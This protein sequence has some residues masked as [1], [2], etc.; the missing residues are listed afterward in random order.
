VI[1][2]IVYFVDWLNGF[3]W[4]GIALLL[5]AGGY[6]LLKKWAYWLM[7]LVWWLFWCLW[8]YIKTWS[9]R[10][11]KSEWG[12]WSD[13]KD[14]AD[15]EFALNGDTNSVIA[16]LFVGVAFLMYTQRKAF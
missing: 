3:D 14:F 13:W 15:L 11:G 8:M 4:L 12:S 1:F 9:F 6:V 16:V 7:W 2:E 5:L 10:I